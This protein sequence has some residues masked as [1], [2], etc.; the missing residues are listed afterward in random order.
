MDAEI[1]LSAAEV[2][3]K[4]AEAVAMNNAQEQA[5]AESRQKLLQQEVRKISSTYQPSYEC[6]LQFVS[7]RRLGQ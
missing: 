1:S 4:A 5:E 2:Q 3:V 6:M 7:E